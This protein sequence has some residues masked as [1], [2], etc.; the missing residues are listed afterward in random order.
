MKLKGKLIEAARSLWRKKTTV[1]IEINGLVNTNKWVD[2]SLLVDIDICKERRS[3]N[4]N[5]YF[6][7]L[8]DRLAGKNGVSKTC[9]KNQLITA[10]GQRLYINND[11][12]VIDSNI[13][14]EKAAEIESPHLKYISYTDGMFHYEVW[15]G[16]ST[17]NSR[18]MA[19]LINGTVVEAQE[20]GIET[21]TPDEIARLAELWK[22]NGGFF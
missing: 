18:E 22:S 4:A 14:P 19:E 7:M 6:H 15:R 16:S 5:S 9:Q 12:A 21:M 8:C 13:P 10:Y 2:K 20:A 3:L 1:V 17:Y 11:I